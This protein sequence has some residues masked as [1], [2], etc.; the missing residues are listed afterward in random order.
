MEAM[1]RSRQMT[2]VGGRF[3][4]LSRPY[5]DDRPPPAL[6]QVLNEFHRR[7]ISYCYRKSSSLLQAVFGGEGDVDLLM[8]T[9]DQHRVQAVHR[10]VCLDAEQPLPEVVHS[11]KREI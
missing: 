10:V 4:M 5:A 3:A 11:I 8:A 7:K 6:V 1:R 9:C 2:Q